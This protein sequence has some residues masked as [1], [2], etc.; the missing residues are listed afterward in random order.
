[1]E[2][3]MQ[4]FQ[5]IMLYYFKKDKNAT[6]MQNMEKV[7]WLIECV[8]SDLQS[9]MLEISLGM[10]LHGWVDQLKLVAIKLRH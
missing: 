6:A 10:L 2:E 9:F 3:N 8:K 1:M 4:Y 7:L 5:H